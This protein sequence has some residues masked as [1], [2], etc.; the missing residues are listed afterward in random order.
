MAIAFYATCEALNID[1]RQLLV[2]VER[3]KDDLDGPFV[4]MFRSLE[5]YARNE[6]GRR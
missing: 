4:N 3:M 6:I 1:I 5:E 2:S